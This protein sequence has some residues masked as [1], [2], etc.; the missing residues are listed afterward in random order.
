MELREKIE[1][2]FG[3]L[4]GASDAHQMIDKLFEFVCDMDM[5]KLAYHHLPPHRADDFDEKHFYARGYRSEMVSEYKRNNIIFSNPVSDY[6][7]GASD[8]LTMAEVGPKLNYS[9]GQ[10]AYLY[11]FY[12]SEHT[13]GLLIPVYGLKNRNGF[14]VLTSKSED[15][16]HAPNEIRLLKLACQEVHHKICQALID[17]IVQSV[18]LTNRETEILTWVARGKSNSVIADIV[19]ISPHT[20]NGY[21]RAVYLKTGVSDRTSAAL[22]GVSKSLIQV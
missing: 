15:R 17:K 9:E 4:E 10:K 12:A 8:A 21:L 2:F 14:F 19:G 20:V 22:V 16:I 18:S 3:K 5:S 1:V 11:Q 7:R 13:N 6:V